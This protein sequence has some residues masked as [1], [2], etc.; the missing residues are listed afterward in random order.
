M[1]LG[2]YK[3]LKSRYLVY[4]QYNTHICIISH[5]ISKAELYEANQTAEIHIYKDWQTGKVGV[6]GVKLRYS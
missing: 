3:G 4:V 6:S 2:L 5:I 1:R